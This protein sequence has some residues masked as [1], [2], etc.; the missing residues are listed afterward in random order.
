MNIKKIEQQTNKQLFGTYMREIRESQKI[1]LRTLAKAIN[2]TT[3]YISDIEKGNNKPP[4]GELLKNIINNLKIENSPTIINKLYD[5]AASERNDIPDDI[6][7][8]LLNNN[9]TIDLLR[10]L[11]NIHDNKKC[12]DLIS[13]IMEGDNNGYY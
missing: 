8:Y 12:N 4:T 11:N 10:F 6:K 2:K 13:K 7:K 3:T 1:P 9:K 5:L